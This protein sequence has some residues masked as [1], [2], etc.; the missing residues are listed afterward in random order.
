MLK[1]TIPRV[2]TKYLKRMLEHARSM[3]TSPGAVYPIKKVV[4]LYVDNEAF[5]RFGSSYSE[6]SQTLADFI[7]ECASAGDPIVSEGEFDRAK[8][9]VKAGRYEAVGMGEAR[10]DCTKKT[11]RFL[12]SSIGYDLATNR[13][14]LDQVL[15]FLPKKWKVKP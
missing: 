10:I 1:K 11:I 6:H 5:L 13:K 7:Q 8:P 4:Q 15:Q 3:P 2:D 12:G 9:P 14:H